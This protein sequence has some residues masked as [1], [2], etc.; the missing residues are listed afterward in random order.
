MA[1][2]LLVCFD[3][4]GVSTPEGV[5]AAK[6]VA[7]LAQAGWD[8]RVVCSAPQSH[9]VLDSG[10]ISLLPGNLGVYEAD[11]RLAH[12]VRHHVAARALQFALQFPD[13]T[14]LWRSAAF[15]A[16]SCAVREWE[17]DIV[18]TR[19]QPFSTHVVGLALKSQ[20]GLPWVAHFSDPWAH[21][22]MIERPRHA[23]RWNEK[24][25]RSTV[26]R[27][28]GLVFVCARNRDLVVRSDEAAV[29]KSLLLP[30]CFAWPLYFSL[31]PAPYHGR[32][33]I[34]HAG[35]LY[36]RRSPRVVLQALS[37]LKTSA[38]D[39]ASTLC[40]TFVGDHLRE[41]EALARNLVLDGLVKFLPA[42]GYTESLSIASTAH[43]FVVIE[44]PDDAEG[45]FLPSKIFDYLPLQRP[46]LGLSPLNGPAARLLSGLGCEVVDPEDVVGTAS[47]LAGWLL[48]AVKSGGLRA[49]YGASD[50]EKY[51]FRIACDTL[52]A[53]LTQA[54]HR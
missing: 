17:P 37:L 7:G 19:A 52:S 25:E 6:T 8:V 28:D 44:A 29:A 26:D 12:L 36:G 39:A 51:D 48:E 32:L 38:P 16:A 41:H 50:I 14:G 53:F 46:I 21:N 54:S 9:S 5:L 30:H 27:A 24:M 49:P 40:V 47:V 31:S 4:P 33:H 1:R 43:A 22:P 11:S 18:Y 3:R 2:I 23:R 35:S 13:A 42:V 34:L 15:A 20:F 10:L 45:T